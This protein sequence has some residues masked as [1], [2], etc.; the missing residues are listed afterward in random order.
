[1]IEDNK[2]RQ[3]KGNTERLLVVR[4]RYNGVYDGKDGHNSSIRFHI[5]DDKVKAKVE[6]SLEPE[7]RAIFDKVVNQDNGYI[8]FILQDLSYDI[9]EKSEIIHTF[10]A[11]QTAY[12]YGEAPVMLNI[13]GLLVD[14]LDNDH[15]SSFMSVYRKFLKG[16]A[17]AERYAYVEITTNNSNWGGAFLNLRVGQSADRDTD[18]T[19]NATFLARDFAIVPSVSLANNQDIEYLELGSRKLDPTVTAEALEVLRQYSAQDRTTLK[20]NPYSIDLSGLPSLSSLLGF[21]ALDIASFFNFANDLLGAVTG[22]VTG[23]TGYLDDLGK[24]VAGYLDAVENGLDSL[25]STY[26]NAS[27]TVAS[28]IDNLQGLH[29]RIQNFPET[30]GDRLKYRGNTNILGSDSISN[31]DA[32]KSTSDQDMKGP[33]RGTGVL[34]ISGSARDQ[35]NAN[36][37]KEL[38]KEQS[39]TDNPQ[40]VTEDD[41]RRKLISTLVL[42]LTIRRVTSIISLASE[43][44]GTSVDSSEDPTATRQVTLPALPTGLNSSNTLFINRNIIRI[45]G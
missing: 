37:R 13:S 22:L 28:N 34:P 39:Q 18:V 42:T 30:L 44:A 33:L 2:F 3:I 15:F 5:P 27:R 6:A 36:I 9:Q 17:A 1:M 11:N 43:P 21:S 8:D 29:T 32:R 10:G 19:F 23:I 38:E 16:T 24:E 35:L 20:N 7:E 4:P 26:D 45:G 40:A 25:L 12:F 41:V 14:D 31:S